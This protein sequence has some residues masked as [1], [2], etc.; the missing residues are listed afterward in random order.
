MVSYTAILHHVK[1]IHLLVS[2]LVKLFLSYATHNIIFN[3]VMSMLRLH[4]IF[5]LHEKQRPRALIIFISHFNFEFDSV[6]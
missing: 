3:P 2:I 6:Q 1:P 5:L 4:N